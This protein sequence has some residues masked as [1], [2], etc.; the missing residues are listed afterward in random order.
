MDNTAKEKQKRIRLL[1]AF[2]IVAS[3]FVVRGILLKTGAIKTPEDLQPDALKERIDRYEVRIDTGTERGGGT[4]LQVNEKQKDPDVL[5]ILSAA[6]LLDGFESEE[7]EHPGV[8]TLP[9]GQEIHGEVIY[10]DSR[11]DFGFVKAEAEYT[12]SVYFSE[13]YLYQMQP[14]ALLYYENRDNSELYAGSYLGRQVEAAGQDGTFLAFLGTSEEG[15]SGSGV[16]AANGYYLGTIVAG[17]EDGSIL[18]IPGNE[19]VDSFRKNH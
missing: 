10:L 5:Y 2:L 15:M 3:M 17:S 13:D 7:G 6:H 9:D 14:D 11:R 8:I 12:H 4:I 16:Y 18:C 19:I 1:L